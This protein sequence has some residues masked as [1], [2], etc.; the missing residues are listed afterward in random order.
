[1]SIRSADHDPPPKAA[2]V[3]G[4]ALK[5]PRREDTP[6]APSGP[7]DREP[8]PLG[9]SEA[10][11]RLREELDLDRATISRLPPERLRQVLERMSQGFYDRA[12]IREQVLRGLATDLETGSSQE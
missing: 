9:L 11:Q 1:M 12:E 7:P 4:A 3:G 6:A 5:V 2:T 8:N 10:T